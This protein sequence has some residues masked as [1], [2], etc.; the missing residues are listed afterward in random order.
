M[1]SITKF[2]ECS[3]PIYACNLACEYCYLKNDY[4]TSSLEHSRKHIPLKYSMFQI[5]SCLSKERLGGECFFSFC[6]HGETTAYPELPSV[7]QVVTK[8]GHFANVTTNATYSSGIRSII[9]SCRNSIDHVL[10]SCSLHYNELVQKN[11]LNVFTSNVKSIKSSG[12]SYI[13]S[14]V[15]NSRYYNKLDSIKEYMLENF[16]HLPAVF[17]GRVGRTSTIDCD[18]DVNAFIDAGKSF[19]SPLFEFCLRH[20]GKTNCRK[21]NAG[22]T[23]FVLDIQSGWCRPCYHL[24]TSAQCFNIFENT[25]Y[26]DFS[27]LSSVNCNRNCVNS[28]HFIALGSC[29]QEECNCTY[30]SIRKNAGHFSNAMK[31]LLNS[32]LPK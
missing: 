1:A 14:L 23:S 32:K 17:I 7:L 6:G 16:G 9:E 15:L 28:S 3:V 21:C 27:K 30:Y 13:V 19:N 20:F 8:N 31:E 18:G 5:A 4:K 22:K 24:G 25:D 2:F 29:P 11:L 10:F 26:L 12:A